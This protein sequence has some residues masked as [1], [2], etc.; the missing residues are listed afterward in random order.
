LRQVWEKN[1]WRKVALTASREDGS[2]KPKTWFASMPQVKPPSWRS[3]TKVGPAPHWSLPR[4][5]WVAVSSSSTGPAPQIQPFIGSAG[6]TNRLWSVS[7]SPKRRA[8]HRVGEL[9]GELLGVLRGRRLEAR[10][11]REKTC[12]DAAHRSS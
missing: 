11:Q 7:P 8:R 9:L 12:E 4:L 1:G 6:D 3:T 10:P 2:P 5:S